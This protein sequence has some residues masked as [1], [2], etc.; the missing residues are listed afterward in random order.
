M[1]QN[2][3]TKTFFDILSQQLEKE[4]LVLK[5]VKIPE[6]KSTEHKEDKNES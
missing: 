4:G 6:E 1:I 5:I 2:K 3:D